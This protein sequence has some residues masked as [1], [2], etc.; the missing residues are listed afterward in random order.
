MDAVRGR[1][2]ELLSLGLF[3]VSGCFARVPGRPADQFLMALSG[4]TMMP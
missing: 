4:H 3:P 2:R 1:A